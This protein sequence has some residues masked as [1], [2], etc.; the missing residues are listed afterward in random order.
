MSSATII[1][2]PGSNVIIN[3]VSRYERGDQTF[4]RRACR[5]AG[6]PGVNICPKCD[7]S[8]IVPNCEWPDTDDFTDCPLCSQSGPMN[9]PDQGEVQDA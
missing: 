5:D 1:S 7:D 2:F 8:G 3:H 9:L 4:W 6:V